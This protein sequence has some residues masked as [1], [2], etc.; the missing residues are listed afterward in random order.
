MQQY[1]RMKQGQDIGKMK[2]KK[3]KK[4]NKHAVVKPVEWFVIFEVVF[5]F[6]LGEFIDNQILW[7]F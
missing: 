3:K 7:Q 4:D 2:K 1:R 6:F 5:C